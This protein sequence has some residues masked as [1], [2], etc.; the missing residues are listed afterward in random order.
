MNWRA[1][2]AAGLADFAENIAT[3]LGGSDLSAIDSNVRTDLL[4]LIGTMPADL[5]SAAANQIVQSGQSKAAT[6]TT[7]DIKKT[8][9]TVIAQVRNQLVA[10][11]APAEQYSLCGFDV[12]VGE[13][14]GVPRS[15]PSGPNTPSG[16]AAAGYSNGTIVLGFD[17]QNPNTNVRY[18][19][20][21]LHGD[22]EPYGLHAVV[23][24]QK[25]TD[26]GC[27][28]GELYQYKVCAVTSQGTSPFSNVAVVYGVGG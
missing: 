8:L 17:G 20:W 11:G 7:V 28:P 21:R 27:V 15:I 19:I 4:T 16:L 18:E 22:T 14:T 2:N 25:F 13:A 6:E 3:L 9:S 12:P 23:T 26:F 10:S 5:S 1:L 24:R